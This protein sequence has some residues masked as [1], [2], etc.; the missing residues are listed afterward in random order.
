M[1][2]PGAPGRPTL[3]VV[4][5]PPGAGKT[6]LAHAIGRGLGCPVI[7]RDEI[8]E[9]MAHATPGYL[10]RP[11]DELAIRTLATFFDT[12]RLLLGRGVT[13]VAESAFQDRLWRPGLEP[14]AELAEIR[15]VRCLVG[16]AQAR[17]RMHARSETDPL[18]A[19]AH[20]DVAHLRALAEA[21]DP[22][23]FDHVHLPVP[24]LHVDTSD[25]YRPEL[26]DV[27]AFA[28]GR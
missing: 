2:G 20:D 18:R 27:V 21:T 28:R 26:A 1:S 5:G 15:I 12:L 3:V 23:A 14:L 25:G 6:T 4:S 8:K 10:P 7:C 17:E 9:G 19:A 16:A 24:T 13:T 22:A 11:G